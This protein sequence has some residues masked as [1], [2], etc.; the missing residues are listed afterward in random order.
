MSEILS[1]Q[2]PGASLEAIQ[3]HYDVG[4][5]FYKLFL[6]DTITYSCAL[7]E[8]GDDLTAA[9][10]RKLDYHIQCSGASGAKRVLD[11]GCGW[12]STLSRLVN[13]H[14]VESATGLT[15]SEEQFNYVSALNNPKINVKVESWT[16]HVPAEPYDSIISIGAFEHFAKLEMSEEDRIAGYRSFFSK[17]H[18]WLKPSGKI[19]LQTIACGN[20][21]REDFSNF[22]ATQIFPESDLPRLS[23]IARACEFLFEIVTYRND[24]MMYG[25]TLRS[26]L[27]RLVNNRAEAVKLVGEEMVAKYEKYFKLLII[28]FEVYGSMDLY[29]IEF[30]KIDR[31]RI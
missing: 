3:Y 21:L 26:W 20:M 25:R 16:D 8:E 31:P 22:F 19:S 18:S 28:A 15:L 23:E 9:Q 11:I 6:D 29:R 5:E 13:V 30:R 7:W 17:C 12:G 1:N 24:R 2:N 14:N 10:I 4:N 27:E